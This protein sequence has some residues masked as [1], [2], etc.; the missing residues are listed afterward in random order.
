MDRAIRATRTL[1]W[2]GHRL[3]HAGGVNPAHRGAPLLLL[4]LLYH[5]FGDAKG[6]VDVSL[7]DVQRAMKQKLQ[8]IMA[9]VYKAYPAMARKQW[10]LDWL[11]QVV[12]AISSCLWTPQVDTFCSIMS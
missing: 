4:L 12:L 8:D 11:A 5:N 2:R 3:L 6:N 9:C 7:N 1:D 10:I